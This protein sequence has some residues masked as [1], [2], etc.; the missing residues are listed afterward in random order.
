MKKF[1]IPMV[2][3]A[4]ALSSGCEEEVPAYS[5]EDVCTILR[6]G[7]E[8]NGI[9]SEAQHAC[10]N[11]DIDP[12][13]V[14]ESPNGGVIMSEIRAQ[15]VPGDWLFDEL[16]GV[17]RR[18]R[19][20]FDNARLQACLAKGIAIRAKATSTLDPESLFADDPDC[21]GAWIP[22][23]V[24]GD[25]CAHELECPLGTSCEAE[26]PHDPTLR[27]LRPATAG[28]PCGEFR[29]C[30]ALSF[31]NQN[32]TCAPLMGIGELCD[33]INADCKEGMCSN[34]VCTAFPGPGQACAG[35]C[36]GNHWCVNDICVP[37]AADGENCSGYR[38][39]A[40]ACSVCR[41]EFV[42]APETQY[43]CLARASAGDACAL[44]DDDH[45]AKGLYC[46]GS[47][48]R[49]EAWRQIDDDCTGIGERCAEGLYCKPF[50]GVCSDLLPTF[51]ESCEASLKCAY[52]LLCVKGVCTTGGPAEPCEFDSDCSDG[53]YCANTGFGFSCQWRLSEGAACSL[54][55]HCETG[56]FCN[57]LNACEKLRT[58]GT[59][60]QF[61]SECA[62]DE[63]YQGKCATS[64]PTSGCGGHDMRNDIGW[65]LGMGLLGV[66]SRRRKED[67]EP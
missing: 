23:G 45:C 62:S 34:G 58:V 55:R 38:P 13:F 3:L 21:V 11:E 61:D 25:E 44:S 43:K 30:G 48:D 56:L 6:S 49:C 7:L 26:D 54:P 33:G 4:A 42:G 9:L 14:E 1:A 17:L 15:C 39:C 51:G 52:D 8:N 57:S 63:C 19:A 64:T 22:L 18:K 27:C 35:P 50:D 40:D 41:P 67:A 60:C 10:S 59:A 36:A 53:L 24:E 16:D 65:L 32:G 29:T 66:L 46:N 20:Q 37:P 5:A 12:V 47:T 2:V 28:S 31:C